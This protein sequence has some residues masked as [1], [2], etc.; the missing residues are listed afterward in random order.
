MK[1]AFNIVHNSDVI[2]SA[3]CSILWKTG[4]VLTA[5]FPLAIQQELSSEHMGWN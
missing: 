5:C 3:T 1:R 2:S 4:E